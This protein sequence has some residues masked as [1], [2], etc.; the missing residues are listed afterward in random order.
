MATAF[1]G[2]S[3]DLAPRFALATGA[4]LRL[5][6][7]CVTPNTP[8]SVALFSRTSKAVGIFGRLWPSD[9]V[10]NF[11]LSA[12]QVCGGLSAKSLLVSELFSWKGDV[13]KLTGQMLQQ[14]LASC[15]F[16]ARPP[17]GKRSHAVVLCVSVCQVVILVSSPSA[18]ADADSFR[19]ALQRESRFRCGFL[20]KQ[21]PARVGHAEQFKT[22]AAPWPLMGAAARLCCAGAVKAAGSGDAAGTASVVEVASMPLDGIPGASRRAQR[23]PEQQRR[24]SPL[25]CLW[26]AVCRQLFGW[27][28][29]RARRGLRR[30]TG[31][32]AR[33]GAGGVRPTSSTTQRQSRCCCSV[34]GAGFLLTAALSSTKMST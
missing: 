8:L 28:C 17:Q 27:R 9:P 15:R 31:R 23:R 21:W 12:R 34:C 18:P 25:C 29:C 26:L 10:R 24:L 3:G 4:G 16:A 20:L 2:Q 14:P 13:G 33:L 7:E 1:V 32:H 30:C 11:A 5:Q 6:Q 19:G 22:A